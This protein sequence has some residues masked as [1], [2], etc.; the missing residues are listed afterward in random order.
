LLAC[1]RR[2]ESQWQ[3]WQQELCIPLVAATQAPGCDAW[4]A[5]GHA[6]GGALPKATNTGAGCMC[7]QVESSNLG[8]VA[9]KRCA[10]GQAEQGRFDLTSGSY[11]HMCVLAVQV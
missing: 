8:Y 11:L 2:C 10:P 5:Q 6:I 4:P 1:C 7:M 3:Q 9:Q